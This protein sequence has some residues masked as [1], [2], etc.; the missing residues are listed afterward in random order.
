MALLLVAG[1]LAAALLLAKPAPAQQLARPPLPLPAEEQR[2]VNVAIDRGVAYLRAAQNPWGTWGTAKEP[3]G[4][5]HMIGYTALPALTLLE[6]GVAADHPAIILA[7][8]AVRVS[9]AKIDT[10]YELALSILFLDRLGDPK[11]RALIETFA[12]RLIAGQTPSGGW[13]YRCPPLTAATQ[14][15]L[16]LVLRQLDPNVG[17]ILL[18]N[19]VTLLKLTNQEPLTLGRLRPAGPDQIGRALLKP[20]GR[21][22]NDLALAKG[23]DRRSADLGM[24]KVV[25]R[26]P[27]EATSP[28]QT[29][30]SLSEPN[31]RGG[32]PSVRQ[33]PRAGQCIKLAEA[34]PDGDGA[35]GEGRPG[36]DRGGGKGEG[37]KPAE[38]P[39]P[40]PAKVVIPP[41]LATLP[42]L[43]EA[44]RF[45]GWTDPK[46]KTDVPTYGTTDNSNTQ[47]AILAL[48]VAQRHGVPMRR[49]ME[50]VVRRFRGSQN[51]DGGWG[52]RY[53]PGGGEGSSP[54]MTCVGLIG[55]AV[56]HG[57]ANNGRPVAAPVKDPL[58]VN[59]FVALARNLGD[60]AGRTVNLPMNNLY[61]LWSVERVAILY[62]LPKI[63]NKDW[64]R[65]GAEILVANQGANGEWEKGGYPGAHPVLDTCLAL[66]FLRRANLATDL[67]NRLPFKPEQLSTDIGQS[68]AKEK[69]PADPPAGGAAPAPP[70]PAPPPPVSVPSVA[71]R[72][73]PE[74]PPAPP[75]TA[76]TLSRAGT[77]DDSEAP[78]EATTGGA[79]WWLWILLVVCVLLLGGSGAA[80]FWYGRG[81][82]EEERKPPRKGKSKKRR[83]ASDG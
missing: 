17:L 39:A 70:P 12:L 74:P 37:A 31:N 41:G 43:R 38:P 80:F 19:E 9:W 35:K 50:L 55:L 46:E 18:P 45:D 52:Y 42:V 14:R 56:G 72:P 77:G 79:R 15:Q 22:Q 8:N 34:P 23:G 67:T 36:G 24:V 20:G 3:G 62:D 54:A 48:W 64:Y 21:G 69:P 29:G 27:G 16:L 7:A 61:F 66:L 58:V 10:T 33:G 75:V 1:A 60:P 4:G 78:K 5:G 28:G 71:T 13:S 73:D 25:F 32:E 47:F 57:L 2:Q 81:R 76:P 82:K 40:E 59:G 6:C 53:A 44:R 68:Q 26:S 63:G 65:W 83:R 49:T 11:D 30:G 51:A